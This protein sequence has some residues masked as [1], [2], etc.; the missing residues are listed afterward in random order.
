[1]SGRKKKSCSNWKSHL[2]SF[3]KIGSSSIWPASQIS[4]LSYVILVEGSIASPG[5]NGSP[6]ICVSSAAKQTL[7]SVC[8]KS[9]RVLARDADRACQVAMGA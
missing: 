7:L 2:D 9:R 1:M 3:A 4:E 8:G 6:T 5:I